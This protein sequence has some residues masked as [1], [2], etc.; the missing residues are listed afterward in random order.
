MDYTNDYTNPVYLA[1]VLVVGVIFATVILCALG[2]AVAH[3]LGH[4]AAR[5]RRVR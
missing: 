4:V 1:M 2:I 3:H 5:R